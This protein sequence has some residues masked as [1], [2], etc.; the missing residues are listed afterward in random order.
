MDQKTVIACP[1]CDLLQ[2]MPADFS[3]GTARCARCDAKLFSRKKNSIDRTL[4]LAV[5]GLI[6]FVL[7]NS[8][9]FLI[10]DLEGN[11]RE[12]ILISGIWELFRQGNVELA[13]LVFVTTFIAPLMQLMCL[14]FVL[15]PLK[16]GLAPRLLPGVFRLALRLQPWSMLDVFM[17][18]ILVSMVKLAKLADIGPGIAS[19]SFLA[20]VF[21]HAAMLASIDSYRIWERWDELGRKNQEPAD[22]TEGAASC[23]ACSLLCP[24]PGPGIRARCPR[25]GAG[26]HS[27]KPGGVGRV[28]ALIVAALIFYI[29]A[30][31]FPVT[32]ITT[33]VD[34][35][36]DTI[37]SSV[38]YFLN[39]GVWP[40]AVVIFTASIVVPLAKI[41]ILSF[42]AASVQLKSRWNPVDRTRLYRFTEIVG[43]WSMVD[44]FVVTVLVALVNV[45]NMAS[46][47]AGSGATWFAAVVVITM[48][49]AEAFDPRLIWDF[50]NNDIESNGT[51]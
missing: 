51:N 28:W 27:R 5:T 4:A 42:L 21:A 13:S 20:F 41:I 3:S 11:V 37:L 31:V 15:T 19:Y 34:V 35:Q 25:C 38:I 33:L 14:V 18:G 16:L 29:P 32:T 43:R 23:H 47:R 6:L 12:T 36:T 39:T 17:L 8:F 48:F 40:I 1:D 30:N 10:F 44:V 46:T 9:P 22:L 45:G 7:A 50:E 24:A 26:L 49:A 2:T